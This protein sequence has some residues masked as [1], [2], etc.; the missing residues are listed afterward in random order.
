[1]KIIKGIEIKLSCYCCGGTIFENDKLN[2]TKIEGDYYLQNDNT[3]LRC[4][5]CS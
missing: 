5:T 2:Y 1:M 3:K 4:K